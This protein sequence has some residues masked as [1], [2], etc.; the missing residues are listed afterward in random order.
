MDRLERRKSLAKPRNLIVSFTLAAAAAFSICALSF[1]VASLGTAWV[2]TNAGSRSASAIAAEESQI[3][4]EATRRRTVALASAGLLSVVG[5]PRPASANILDGMTT[6]TFLDAFTVDIPSD[7]EVLKDTNAFR[8]WQG[9]G[10]GILNQYSVSAKVVDYKSLGDA[11]N[12]TDVKKVA[13]E[14]AASRPYSDNRD[15][16]TGRPGSDII[17]STDNWIPDAG[18]PV[19]KFEFINE[20]IRE[21]I[22]FVLVPKASGNVLGSITLRAPPRLWFRDERKKK[23]DVISKSLKLLS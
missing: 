12:G 13:E 10:L 5:A 7:Y 20:V 6:Y 8:V 1:R 11:F 23:F 18:V 15:S 2:A 16:L 22:V 17:T 14:L 4:D 3:D 19:W 9:T 21:L